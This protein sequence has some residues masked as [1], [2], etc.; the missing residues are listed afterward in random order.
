MTF[1]SQFVPSWTKYKLPDRV[2]NV[3]GTKWL[4]GGT[5][6]PKSGYVMTTT[7]QNDLGTKFVLLFLG[8]ETISIFAIYLFL[9]FYHARLHLFSSFSL[10]LSLSHTLSL[11]HT[12]IWMMSGKLHIFREWADSKRKLAFVI[13]KIK[14]QVSKMASVLDI[15]NSLLS[16]ALSRALAVKLPISILHLCIRIVYLSVV[17]CKCPRQ[18]QRK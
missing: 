6:L 5:K 7:V 17:Y 8:N 16:L 3:M 4:F 2:R 15:F 1:K 10:S 18:R 9:N 14:A 12:H 11:T 13:N